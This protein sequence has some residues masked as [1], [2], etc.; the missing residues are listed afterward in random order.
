MEVAT[1]SRNEEEVLERRSFLGALAGPS[2]GVLHHFPSVSHL[3]QRSRKTEVFRAVHS[4]SARPQLLELK[5][6]RK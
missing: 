1:W 3:S 2:P 5:E 4:V 6:I